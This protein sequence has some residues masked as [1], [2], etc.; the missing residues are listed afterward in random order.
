MEA[1]RSLDAP[2]VEGALVAPDRG[3]RAIR[4]GANWGS[5]RFVIEVRKNRNREVM[6]ASCRVPGLRREWE[7]PRGMD[8]D[9]SPLPA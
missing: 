4:C 7:S 9:I 5:A 3:G 1:P 8:I 2:M 6:I